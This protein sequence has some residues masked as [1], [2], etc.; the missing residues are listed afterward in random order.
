VFLARSSVALDDDCF[1]ASLIGTRQ[2]GC[3]C[4]ITN[5]QRDFSARDPA[6]IYGVSKREHV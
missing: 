2:T 4:L 5:H 3:V 1:Q 6:F